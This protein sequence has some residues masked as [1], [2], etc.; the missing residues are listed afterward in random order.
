MLNKS[1]TGRS[2]VVRRI[3]AVILAVCCIFSL[4]ACS[5]GGSSG[6]SSQASRPSH[7]KQVNIHKSIQDML[8]FDIGDEFIDEAEIANDNIDSDNYGKMMIHI[9]AG[10][11]DELEKLLEAKFGKPRHVELVDIPRY[12]EHQYADELRKTSN[13]RYFA[14]FKSGTSAKSVVVDI[15][16]AKQAQ[17]QI[18]F[19]FS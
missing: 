3:T 17:R 9:K 19:I 2:M 16:L 14:N 11:E 18:L 12:Q 4:C 7:R 13:I 5:S 10:K 1:I 8:G 6:G 15:Y